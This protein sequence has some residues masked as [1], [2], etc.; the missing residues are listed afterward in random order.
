MKTKLLILFP[1]VVSIILPGCSNNNPYKDYDFKYWNDCKSLNELISYVKD[2]VNPNSENFIPKNDRIVT[3]DFDGTLFGER[4]PIYLEWL[5]YQDYFD[6]YFEGDKDH[7]ITYSINEGE[8]TISLR[9]TYNEIEEFKKDI[10]N[11][12]LEQDEAHAGAYLFAGLT[13]EEYK[14]YV[15][16]FAEKEAQYF[17][18]LKYKDMF[19]LPMKEIVKYLQMNDFI[20]YLCSG[21]DRFMLRTLACETLN[22]EA[23]HVI[24]MTTSLLGNAEDKVI[25]GDKL[26]YKSVK[27]IKSQLI[28]QEIGKS[29]VLSFGNS[30]GDVDMHLFAL[31]YN[32]YKSKAFMVVADDTQRERGYTPEQVKERTKDWGKFN[33][34]SMKNDWKTIYGDNVIYKNKF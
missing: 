27:N 14:T 12:Y 30:S 24:G 21:T 13:I 10:N 9:D 22:I 18:N 20:T 32:K 28:I 2:V 26:I 1:I 4:S 33:L 7:K 15:L 6:K 5:F 16:N 31:L 29:S 11:E 23:N 17:T 25:R 3:F 19:F 8:R 34:F